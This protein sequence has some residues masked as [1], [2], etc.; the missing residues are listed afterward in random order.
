MVEEFSYTTYICI[1]ISAI[2][3][4]FIILHKLFCK[5]KN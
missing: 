2:D 5:Y 4:T 3:N 1:H